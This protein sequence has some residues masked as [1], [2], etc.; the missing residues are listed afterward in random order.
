MIYLKRFILLLAIFS[1]VISGKI[2]AGRVVYAIDD[3]SQKILELRKQIEELTKQ[4]ETYKKNINQ[5]QKEANTLQREIGLIKENIL[6]L[7]NQ[8]NITSKQIDTTKLNIQQIE[9]N[10][11]SAQKN[12]EF[13]K[14]A[15]AKLLGFVYQRDRM[16]LVAIMMSNPKLSDFTDQA[17]QVMNLNENLVALVAQLQD[18]KTRMESDKKE[19]DKKKS[20]LENLSLTQGAQKDSLAYTSE[21]KDKLLTVTKGQEVKYQAMLSE[22]EQKEAAFYEELKNAEAEAQKSGIFIVHITAPSVP[23]AGTKLFAMPYDDYYMTQGYGMTSYARRGAYG[24]A[25]HNGVDIT[26]GPGSGIKSIGGGV[27]LASG[28]NDGF[29]NWV[30]VRHDNDMVSIYGHMR[31]QSGLAVGT[32]VDSSSIIGYEGSTGNSTG[33]HLHLSLYKDFFTYINPKNGQL[34]FNY[35]EGSLN[36]LSYINK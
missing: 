34:Y 25:P 10:I 26:S 2:M 15:I 31:V 16:G 35:F 7:E 1:L 4:G 24:G 5:K 14:S 32:R 9:G 29:G 30:A 28:Y 8:I 36:P 20:D 33:S 18:V 19:L 3:A 23:R 13:Q 11:T 21:S 27:I 12:I 6:R 17:Q 22:I